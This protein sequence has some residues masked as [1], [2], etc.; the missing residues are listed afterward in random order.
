M[1]KEYSNVKIED[2]FSSILDHWNNNDQIELDIVG[3][4]DGDYFI[5]F[6][7]DNGGFKNNSFDM[8]K[9][10]PFYESYN[11]YKLFEEDCKT[12]CVEKF[13]G[14]KNEKYKFI[15]DIIVRSGQFKWMY[16]PYLQKM[17]VEEMGFLKRN[18]PIKSFLTP[19]IDYKLVYSETD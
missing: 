15:Y 14:S 6:C 8:F 4:Q 3:W 18:N 11:N 16:N 2:F 10:L 17:I 1:M 19:W 5:E 9:N 12:Y 13:I 7:T